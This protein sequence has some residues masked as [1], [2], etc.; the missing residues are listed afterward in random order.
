MNDFSNYKQKQMSF[1]FLFRFCRLAISLCVCFRV[2]FAIG[3]IS[4]S[5]RSLSASFPTSFVGFRLISLVRF[6]H[7]SEPFFLKLARRKA[8]KRLNT[9]SCPMRSAIVSL[10]VY[11]N[12]DVS[13][14][15]WGSIGDIDSIS[16]ETASQ[17]MSK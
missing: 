14:M 15:I 6:G 5:Y 10:V 7:I 11:K 1:R 3:L 13:R 2:C 8:R 17:M 12:V 9:N 4:F 16:F